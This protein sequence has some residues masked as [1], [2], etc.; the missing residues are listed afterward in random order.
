MAKRENTKCIKFLPEIHFKTSECSTALG[1]CRI[2][3]LLSVNL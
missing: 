1:I 2:K 3:K